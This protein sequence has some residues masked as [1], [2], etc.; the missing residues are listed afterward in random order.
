[1]TG[2]PGQT[3]QTGSPPMTGSQPRPGM[4]PGD[5]KGEFKKPDDGSQR[6]SGTDKETQ[7]QNR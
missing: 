3:G 2:N 5:D 6:G 7:N 4:T 1:M